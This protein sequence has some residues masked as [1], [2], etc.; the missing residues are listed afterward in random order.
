MPV[1][2]AADYAGCMQVQTHGVLAPASDE[3]SKLRSSM[4]QVASPLASGTSLRDSSL[5]FNL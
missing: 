5:V 4:K 2:N 3:L 1:F